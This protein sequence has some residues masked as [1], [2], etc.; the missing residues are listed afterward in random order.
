MALIGTLTSGVSALRTF[1]K[2]LEVIG[3][4]ISNVNTTGYKSA[5]ASY[6][7]TFSNTLRAATSAS[8]DA[9][10][11]VGTGVQ[12]TGISTNFTQGSLASTGNGT[13][14]AVS[15]QGY[16]VVQDSTGRNYATRD[17]AFRFDNDGFLVN[18]LGYKVLGEDGTPV[19]VEDY[20]EKASVTIGSN[21]VITVFEA[22]GTSSEAATIG[23]LKIGD[24]SKLMKSG[25]NLYDFG[26]TGAAVG[27]MVQ[28]G[29][30]GA[31]T[32]QTGRLEMS[33]VDLTEQ[34]SELITTQR[35]FQAGSRLIT[36]S[37]SVLEDIVN[38]KR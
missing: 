28:P 26:S 38:L 13:D 21:G 18:S 11:Q 6:G 33:N 29:S 9:A 15:G 20:N 5:A 12:I 35:S 25:N 1:S 23:L 3:N 14:L 16:F 7:D 34:F 22:D 8:G 27:D 30:E 31:G 32:I 4:N 2:G 36:V 19:Q 24:Q 37:D 10:I 17:G